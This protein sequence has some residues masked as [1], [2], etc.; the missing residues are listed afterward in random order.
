MN[1]NEN[2][3]ISKKYL[4]VLAQNKISKNS[5]LSFNGLQLTGNEPE[6]AD[7][8]NFTWVEEIEIGI[9]YSNIL[10]QLPKF[11]KSLKFLRIIGG[12]ITDIQAIS[13]LPKLQELHLMSMKLL[14]DIQP[15][16]KLTTLEAL[17]LHDSNVVDLSP[18]ANLARLEDLM[19]D[20]ALSE[21]KNLTDISP[22]AKLTKLQSLGITHS[23]LSDIS[24]LANLKQISDLELSNNQYLS[25]ISPL[26][27][28]KK[29]EDLSMSYCKVADI[30]S[31]AGL[32]KLKTFDLRGN[33]LKETVNRGLGKEVLNRFPSKSEIKAYLQSLTVSTK[34]KNDIL[35]ALSTKPKR[36]ITRPTKLFPPISEVFYENI[37]ENQQHFMPLATISLAAIDENLDGQIHL[38]YYYHDPYCEAAGKSYNEFIDNYLGT[39]DIIEGKYKFKTDFNFFAVNPENLA[40]KQEEMESYQKQVKKNRLTPSRVVERLGKKPKGLYEESYPKDEQGENLLFVCQVNMLNFIKTSHGADIFL[41]YD[42]KNQRAIQVFQWS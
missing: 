41:F 32:S 4:E 15:L 40:Y 5:F 36:K 37:E 18:L 35:S 16:A 25:D 20:Y 38:V 14:S 34:E 1:A 29:L 17:S 11:P 31:L 28:L 2:K 9:Y 23:N 13:D 39:F 30:S 19:L 10:I 12:K 3:D 6:L 7:L 33:P 21:N 8:V 26:A 27:K 42:K 22:L 24:P